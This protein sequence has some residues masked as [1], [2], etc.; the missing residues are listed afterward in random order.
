MFGRKNEAE[1]ATAILAQYAK[2]EETIAA[3]VANMEPL[4]KELIEAERE[5]QNAETSEA[6][7]EQPAV[8]VAKARKRLE[9]ARGAID[10]Q[11]R[12]LEG[13][14][15]RLL[16]TVAEMPAAHENLL[17]TLPE[18]DEAVK[19]G[20]A[21][22][23]AAACNAFGQV[24]GKRRAIEAAIGTPLDLPEPQ[25]AAVELDGAIARPHLRLAGLKLAIENS[26]NRYASGHPAER[27]LSPYQVFVVQRELRGL[28][29]GTLIVSA[30]LPAG[31]L[32]ALDGGSWVARWK[33]PEATKAANAA[34]VA[35]LKMEAAQQQRLAKEAEERSKA[36]AAER[37]AGADKDAAWGK[38]AYEGPR[39]KPPQQ[40]AYMQQFFESSK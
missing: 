18:H 29:I 25:A 1:A 32:A 37:A 40:S 12:K 35:A 24:M 3:E 15:A 23:W 36:A 11:G 30:S 20:F 28:P 34:R 31:R 6:L 9:A 38:A 26:A 13:L 5:V 22:E 2:I 14:R 8:P 27:E 10:Q 19:A 7:S 4:I 21:K 39:A 33:D 17:P 16:A